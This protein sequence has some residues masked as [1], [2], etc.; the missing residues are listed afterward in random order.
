MTGD[1]IKN[2][3]K[4]KLFKA[5]AQCVPRWPELGSHDFVVFA[6]HVRV[7]V[8]LVA[9]KEFIMVLGILFSSFARRG[10]PVPKYEMHRFPSVVEI[11]LF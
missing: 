8:I 3:I 5:V 11:L 10:V 9:D 7:V 6:K 2:K 4:K 1:S